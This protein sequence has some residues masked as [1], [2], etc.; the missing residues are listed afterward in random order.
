MTSDN[1]SGNGKVSLDF[2]VE[3]T[4]R[5]YTC[6]WIISGAIITSLM[7]NCF[8]MIIM[9]MFSAWKGHLR[10]NLNVFQVL[11]LHPHLWMK[12]ISCGNSWLFVSL[13]ISPDLYREEKI[14]QSANHMKSR[15]IQLTTTND[16]FCVTFAQL[17]RKCSIFSGF[18]K[19]LNYYPISREIHLNAD[20][21][22][23]P[24]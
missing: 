11:E 19:S 7:C 17:S 10:S 21:T 1:N 15:P 18:P 23:I 2:F 22:E 9:L 14:V 12:K 4:R 24:I 20:W 5:F 8:F 13:G 6:P 3:S 16:C